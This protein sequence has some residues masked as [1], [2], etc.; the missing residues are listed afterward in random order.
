MEK[1][2]EIDP[3][4]PWLIFE[5]D[6]V[7]YG[8]STERVQSIMKKP[9]LEE[10]QTR[11][12]DAPNYIRN[13]VRIREHVVPTLDLR[14]LYD[15]VSVEEEYSNF[16]E[17]IDARKQDHIRWVNELDRCVEQNDEFKLAH[18]PHQCAFGKWFYSYHSEHQVIDFM[19]R[20]I[21]DPHRRLHEAAHEA[22][23]CPQE[24][25]TCRRGE[26]VKTVMANLKEKLVPQILGLLDEAKD[27]FRHR[28]QEKL[29]VVEEGERRIAVIVDD[30]KSI[31]TLSYVD[32]QE[33]FSELMKNRYVYG[34]GKGT[35]MDDL[36]LMIQADTLLDLVRMGKG[37]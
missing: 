25:S 10:V 27:V 4:I 30:V 26:C 9:E 24:H 37:E 5:L 6:G 31:D 11:L 20:K 17:M 32:G 35:K 8:L 19:L 22:L 3:K 7:L 34:V 1:Q 29:I 21:E 23:A 18:D 14:K 33:K 2:V 15:L 28:Y 13:M 16:K 36:I 12:P